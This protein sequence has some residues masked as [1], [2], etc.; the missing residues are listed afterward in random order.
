MSSVVPDKKAD[1]A[2]LALATTRNFK[3]FC[4]TTT[5]PCSPQEKRSKPSSA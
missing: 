4:R 2:G 5:T 3:G 1:L